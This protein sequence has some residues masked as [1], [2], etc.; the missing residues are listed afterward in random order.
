MK[1]VRCLALA[2][3]A[4]VAGACSSSVTSGE[5]EASAVEQT[6]RS[7]EA[8]ADTAANRNGGNLMGGN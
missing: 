1:T 7:D 4:L 8:A 2:V 5:P 3:L 6:H